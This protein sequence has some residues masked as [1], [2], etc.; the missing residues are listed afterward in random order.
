MPTR[1]LAASLDLQGDG[2]N[3][4]ERSAVFQAIV[5]HWMLQTKQMEVRFFYNPEI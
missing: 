1:G 3:E 2:G 4:L 5:M